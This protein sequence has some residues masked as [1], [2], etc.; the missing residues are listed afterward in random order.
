MIIIKTI[1]YIS[2]IIQSPDSIKKYRHNIFSKLGTNNITET[3]AYAISK[4]LF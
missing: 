4:K 2:L 3:L 1:F